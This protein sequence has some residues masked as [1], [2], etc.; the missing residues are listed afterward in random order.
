MKNQENRNDSGREYQF[1][2]LEKTIWLIVFTL[3]ITIGFL[4]SLYCLYRGY[5]L[6]DL[7]SALVGL[8]GMV[9]MTLCLKLRR[10]FQ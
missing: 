9:S 2:K 4:A 5:I 8:S 6:Q 7:R 3:I 1:F 10:A